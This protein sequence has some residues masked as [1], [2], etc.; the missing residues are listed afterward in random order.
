MEVVG[1]GAARG[2]E[3]YQELCDRIKYVNIDPP[4]SPI[5]SLTLRHFVRSKNR[6]NTEGRGSRNG[7]HPLRNQEKGG[8]SQKRDNRTDTFQI[9]EFEFLKESGYV[10]FE[11]DH[12]SAGLHLDSNAPLPRMHGN[13]CLFIL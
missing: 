13:D 9:F 11:R 8:L 1:E 4:P 10:M 6:L 3:V 12:T 2:K 5:L 7:I